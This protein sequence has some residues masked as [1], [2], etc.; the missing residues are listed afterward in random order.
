M[1]TAIQLP[2]GRQRY[3]DNAGLPLSGGKLYTYAAGTATPKVTYQDADGLSAH[4]NPII[5]DAK[6]EAVVYWDGAYKVDLKAS[7]DTQV[8]GWP[9]DNLKTDPFGFAAAIAA[10]IAAGAAALA[11]F[12][13]SLAASAGSSLVGFLQAGV[14]AIL[15]TVQDKLRERVSILDF[16]AVG[17]DATD[18]LAA[19]NNVAAYIAASARGVKVH[20]PAGVYRLSAMPTFD[21]SKSFIL[22]GEGDASKIRL[23]NGVGGPTL[24]IGQ[25]TPGTTRQVV[26]DIFFQ[27]PVSGTSSGIRLW[28]ANTARIEGCVFQSQISGILLDASF[29]AEIISNVF[30]VCSTYGIVSETTPCHNLIVRRNNFFS[31][32]VAGGGQTIRLNVASDNIVIEDNDFEQCNV[33][34]RLNSCTAVSV[35]GNYIEYCANSIFDFQGTCRNVNIEGNWLALGTLSATISNVNGGTLSNNTIFD[36]TVGVAASC[37][38]FV[39]GRNYKFGTGTLGQ[40]AWTTP[41]L[42]GTFA[43]QANYYTGQYIKGEDNKVK[44]RGNLLQGAA[45]SLIFN[46]PAGYRPSSVLTFATASA[47][48]PGLSIVEVRVNGDVWCIQRDSAGGTGLNGIEFEATN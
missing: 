12:V 20:I 18:N 33:S 29:A 36:Q 47:A 31:V 22:E 34:M 21:V 14:G 6:G 26:K 17:D 24:T 19:F 30:D 38:D 16:G 45:N 23:T 15:R 9:V 5:L 37:V 3:Y 1:T 44:V 13:A 39:V 40:S 10:A 41:V 2:Q 42:S 27:G 25:A 46:L 4:T 28:N 11:A 7:D 48:G 35:R 8:T 43:Q 32:G